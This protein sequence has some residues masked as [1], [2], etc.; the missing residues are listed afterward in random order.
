MEERSDKTPYEAIARRLEPSARLLSCKM[1]QGGVSAQT[2]YMEVD[3]G[4]RG[5][6]KLVVR[7][8]GEA[9]LRREP[10]VARHEYELLKL[11][12]A[13]GLPVAKPYLADDSGEIFSTPYIVVEYMEGSMELQ[14]ADPVD[15]ALQLAD[16]LARV[17]SLPSQTVRQAKSFLQGAHSAA[18]DKLASPPEKLDDS[19]SEGLIRETLVKAWPTMPQNEDAI[20]HGDYWPG[21]VLWREDRLA[22]IIDWEDAACG[23]PLS[24]VG[25][26][27]LELLWNYSEEAMAAFTKRYRSLMRGLNYDALPC[28][29]LYAALRP[30]SKLSTWGLEAGMEAAMREKHARFVREATAKL[31]EIGA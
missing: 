22:A 30:A 28:W 15:R 2:A 20:L 8:H 23:D 13:H 5:L 31:G 25:N 1:L 6:M 19:L 27:R 10:D 18:A 14:P 11:L 29:D 4:G 24:D 7:R 3:A 26:A 9:D 12:T 16:E 21:N 17:H